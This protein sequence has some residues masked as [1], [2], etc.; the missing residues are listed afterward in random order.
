MD[1]GIS[2]RP[3]CIRAILIDPTVII[4]PSKLQNKI[5]ETYKQTSCVWCPNKTT[6]QSK[7]VKLMT[8]AILLSAISYCKSQGKNNYRPG[9]FKSINMYTA[10]YFFAKSKAREHKDSMYH[11]S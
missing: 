1:R 11:I 2:Y 4:M 3:M 9:S 7:M 6:R 10:T 8:T 5:V